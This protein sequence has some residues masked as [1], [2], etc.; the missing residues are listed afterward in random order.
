M[1]KRPL[2]INGWPVVVILCLVGSPCPAL[3][4]SGAEEKRD[5]MHD[6]QPP[7]D[8]AA[9]FQPPEHLEF[10][11]GDYR[12]PL[13][14]Q[15]GT[16]ITTV[17][18]WEQQRN[19]IRSRWH[20]IMGQWPP[21]IDRPQVEVVTDTERE[22]GVRQQHLRL[23]IAL[24]GEMVH[25]LLLVPEGD[26]PFPAAL[27]VYYDAQSGAGLG[28]PRR[29]FGWQLSRRGF[30]TLS[31]GK[32]NTGVNLED[33]KRIPG[34]GD[35][36]FGPT[37]T[38]LSVQP[39]SALA[40]AASNAR[41]F[42]AAREEVIADRIGIVGHSF[43]GKWA[44]LAAC[45]DD[46]FACAAWSDPGIVFDERDRRKQ[47]PGGSVNYWDPWYLGADWSAHQGRD[48]VPLSQVAR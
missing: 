29:D 15:D 25:A 6:R 28:T 31:I 45:L 5:A 22:G 36:Y 41:L 19:A 34:R 42:L 16:R 33:P 43:G 4:D 32:P 24:G 47:N 48:K 11:L 38:D 27:V 7:A 10:K 9:C 39:L 14:R 23:G 44:L 1:R 12:S 18:E 2:R 35:P 46:G 26:G 21:P 30:V 3:D 8:L 40:Y 20:N 37:G 17:K 13:L